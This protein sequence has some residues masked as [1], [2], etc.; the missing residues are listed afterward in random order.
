LPPSACPSKVSGKSLTTNVPFAVFFIAA[1][2]FIED[3]G[4]A[5]AVAM[6]DT[7]SRAIRAIF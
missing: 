1:L 6:A 4:C 7:K 3:E 2:G 5:L